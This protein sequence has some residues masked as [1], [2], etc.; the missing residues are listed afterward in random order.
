[1][2]GGGGSSLNP[3]VCF[4]R[5]WVDSKVVFVL[6]QGDVYEFEWREERGVGE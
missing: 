3:T 1:M 5:G 4:S 6:L 2:V